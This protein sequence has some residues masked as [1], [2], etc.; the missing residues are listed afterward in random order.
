VGS[1]DDRHV[2][3]ERLVEDA[4]TIG[5]KPLRNTG[6]D[7]APFTRANMLTTNI[8]TKAQLIEA[9]DLAAELEHLL[10]C[11]YSFAAYSLKRSTAEG[12]SET[13]VSK[14]R[15]WGSSVTLIARQEMEHL[16]LVM[17]MLSS[18]GA[19]PYFKRPNFPQKLSIFGSADLK[20][21]LTRLDGETVA[22]FQWFEHPSP[23]PEPGYCDTDPRL[24]RSLLDARLAE[25]GVVQ[26][27]GGYFP[28]P[29]LRERRHDPA[30]AE[31]GAISFS[32]IQDLYLQIWLAFF[33]VADTIGEAAL[34]SGNPE[35]Q[36]W[37]GPGS[38]Y[39]GSMNDLNQ[40]G[41]DI[42]RVTDL[43]SMSCAVLEILFQGEGL[44]APKSYVAHTHY[45][46]FSK[47]LNEMRAA[48]ELVASRPVVRNPLTR[49]HP[50][51]TAPNE[52]NLITRVE[53]REV[54]ETTNECYELMLFVLLVL[55]GAEPLTLEQRTTLTDA[56]FFPMMTMFIRPLS[57]ILT[58]LPAF[59]GAPGNAGPGF[60]LSGAEL[61]L[62]AAKTDPFPEIQRRLD[63]L[64]V[65]FRHLTI[66]RSGEPPKIAER[67]RY[68]G[69]NM[70][71]LAEDFRCGFDN[72]GR[73][74]DEVVS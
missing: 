5:G 25:L 1:D 31:L 30:R 8:R 17:N 10:L 60:E 55:Y 11:Q 36:I 47:V 13:Q 52:V 18:V 41:V 19:E 70:Q 26:H 65:A 22:R 33:Y 42:I 38:P 71:R 45:C 69:E 44:L 43:V 58:Q 27:H 66:V 15:E 53:T 63:R 14:A 73:S 3:I 21:E 49:M 9:L 67:L 68:L 46:L 72:V 29:E 37:G 57:E 64:V 59:D 12:L 16:G 54:A 51:I 35:R 20:Q 62:G 40:Y 50:D 7:A 24:A 2:Y 23:A 6:S 74:Q 34:F 56:A 28:A 32:S 61:R 48:P 4:R 39:A